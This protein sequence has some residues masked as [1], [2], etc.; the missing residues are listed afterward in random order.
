V[1]VRRGSGVLFLIGLAAC[2][3]NFVPVQ[4]DFGHADMGTI[5]LISYREAGGPW[6]SPILSSEDATDTFYILDVKNEYEVVYV[7]V[8][9]TGRF[10]AGAFFGMRED[11]SRFDFCHVYTPTSAPLP[12]VPVSGQMEQAGHVYMDSQDARNT[13]S[14][15]APWNFTLAVPP[16]VHDFIAM[17]QD[18]TAA[19]MV[20][21][22]NQTITDA[23]Q[24]PVVDLSEDG[25]AMTPLTLQV[26]GWEHGEL[27][28]PLP[29]LITANGGAPLP[30]NYLTVFV[31]P[32]Q[33]L[34][35][36][37]GQVLQVLVEPLNETGPVTHQRYLY[38]PIDEQSTLD[39][40]LLPS[41][42]NLSYSVSPNSDGDVT[43]TWSMIP[44]DG[45]TGIGFS[46]SNNTGSQDVSATIA[47]LD[48]HPTNSL[49]F[50]TSAPGFD[51][52]WRIDLSQSIGTC[53]TVSSETGN[54][55]VSSSICTSPSARSALTQSSMRQHLR[56]H[57]F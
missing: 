48:A 47:W 56:R 7:C 6:R 17:P 5:A 35:P 28:W 40:Q 14:M 23:F 53:L 46:V 29:Q 9:D 38:A 11:V 13:S 19:G 45:Y 50:D 27:L 55:G 30:V 1:V 16:G 18:P 54:V 43:E 49:T 57:T 2:G 12:S 26:A 10:Q 37:D 4:L 21:R 32:N 44:F 20:L 8:D 36:N 25:T 39:F 22:R 33:L 31:A 52:A 15:T 51:A 42:G 41:L 34:G 24:E 3:D